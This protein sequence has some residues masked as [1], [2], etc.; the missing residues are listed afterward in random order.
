[1][2]HL[3]KVLHRKVRYGT[4]NF[5]KEPA[6]SREE[7][8]RAVEVGIEVTNA[9]IDQ[10]YDLI[11]TGE[12]GIGNTTASSAVLYAFTGAPID[13]VVGRGAG[14]TDEAFARKKAVVQEAVRV[15]RPDPDDPSMCSPRW[16]V[17]IS[18][19]WP[20]P[21]WPAPPAGCRWSPTA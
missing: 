1:M 9:A 11:G 2:S 21:I 4:A 7:A 17:S 8:I 5:L 18:P 13:R 20:A 14:L 19:A 15:H 10:G 3:P 16:A 6:M 12:I